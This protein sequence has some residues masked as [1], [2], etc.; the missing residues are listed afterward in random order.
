MN[1]RLKDLAPLTRDIDMPCMDGLNF[2]FRLM[3]IVML[4]SLTSR[5][6]KVTTITLKHS[7]VDFQSRP[8]HRQLET[9]CCEKDP[10][11]GQTG[12]PVPRSYR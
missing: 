11:R 6:S 8:K 9:A 3:P 5:G 1:V 4:S 10:R 12:S 7:A 2:L